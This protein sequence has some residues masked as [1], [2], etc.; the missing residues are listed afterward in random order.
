MP[1]KNAMLAACA[2]GT[3]VVRTRSP[4]DNVVSSGTVATAGPSPAVDAGFQATRCAAASMEVCT[5]P[6]VPPFA[7][8]GEATAR[9]LQRGAHALEYRLDLRVVEVGRVEVD[10]LAIDRH[11][12]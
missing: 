9:P 10:R 5:Q 1:T 8:Q 3:E 12:L 6:T 4:F 7:S 11:R 2:V